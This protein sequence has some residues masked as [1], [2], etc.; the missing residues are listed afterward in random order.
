MGNFSS[1]PRRCSNQT[2][3]LSQ[4]RGSSTPQIRCIVCTLFRF[5][6]KGCSFSD[7]R[8]WYSIWDKIPF[9]PPAGLQGLAR[10][11]PPD[12]LSPRW[13]ANSA[14]RTVHAQSAVEVHKCEW[15]SAPI[16]RGLCL[17]FCCRASPATQRDRVVATIGRKGSGRLLRG[18]T[19][20]GATTATGS[21]TPRGPL[22]GRSLPGLRTTGAASGT[23]TSSS[24]TQRDGG[25]RGPA[26][27]APSTTRGLRTLR[28]REI[29]TDRALTC[30]GTTPVW[31]S[32]ATPGTAH[33]A[34]RAPRHRGEPPPQRVPPCTAMPPWTT[35]RF[36]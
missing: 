7:L 33:C 2:T 10:S 28:I 13:P 9:C 15:T 3:W 21:R 34:G 19:R 32:S 24:A 29:G 35:R 23:S 22:A 17:V 20:S 11:T 6:K 12:P 18:A 31:P 26:W 27:P 36:Y 5:Y 4:P 16:M 8:C 25:C 30:N 14:V 1:L